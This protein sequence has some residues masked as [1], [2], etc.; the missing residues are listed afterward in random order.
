MAHRPQGQVRESRPGPGG[1]P[2]FALKMAVE[3]PAKAV[4]DELRAALD[5]DADRLVVDV[6][7]ERV[8]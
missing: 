4:E 5:R 2:H 3:V 8:D 1:S 7:F 6:G